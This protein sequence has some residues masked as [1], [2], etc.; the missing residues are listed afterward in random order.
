MSQAPEEKRVLEDV[1]DEVL[2]FNY[3]SLRTLRDIL[4]RPARV[5]RAFA[6]GDRT[7]YTPTMRV[8]FGVLTWLFLLSII[9]GGF[10][11]LIVRASAQSG[12]A[13]EPFIREG[14]RDMDA[15]VAAVSSMTAIL[16]VPIQSAFVITGALVM[17]RFNT[18]L[19]FIQ[20]LQCYFI[21]VTVS[22]LSST[23]M[24]TVSTFRPD[25][26]FIAPVF[27]Y[28]LFVLSAGAVIHAVFSN[29]WLQ[30]LIRTAIMLIT[31]FVLFSLSTLVTMVL[32][33]LYALSSVPANF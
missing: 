29:S 23:I 14:R 2:S 1:L 9:W 13:L 20:A 27:N 17:H 16:Y 10:G 31:V 11:E 28:G 30:T 12:N 21:P 32:G 8:W 19:T 18:S 24:L 3:R 4:F 22:T 5:A 33:I 7:T 26:L 25:W 6:S 15:V